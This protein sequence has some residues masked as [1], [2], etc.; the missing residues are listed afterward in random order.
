VNRKNKGN[1]LSVEIRNALSEDLK[2]IQILN[3]L[4]VEFD[5]QFDGTIQPDWATSE[6][7]IEFIS[8]RISE[9]DGCVLI[10][11]ADGKIIGYLI[12]GITEAA[13]YRTIELLGEL[14]EM[15]V[16]EEYRGQKIGEQLVQK[17]FGWCKEKKLNRVRVEVSAPNLKGIN[18]YHKQGFEDFNLILEKDI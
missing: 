16:L 2:S 5:S 8:E 11:E 18:F 14:E 10:A 9:N 12:G 7:G 15:V 3:K 13:S 17:F 1:I 6:D 4:L